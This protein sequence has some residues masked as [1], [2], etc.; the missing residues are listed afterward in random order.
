MIEQAFLLA[1]KLYTTLLPHVFEPLFFLVFARSLLLKTKV[2]GFLL[3]SV[4]QK[5]YK[6]IVGKMIFCLVLFLLSYVKVLRER[7]DSEC[8]SVC[9]YVIALEKV[10]LFPNPFNF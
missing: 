2:T 5:A 7:E 10:V 1:L 6:I 9:I 4:K 8:L 3:G